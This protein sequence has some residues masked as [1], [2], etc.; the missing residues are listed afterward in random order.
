MPTYTTIP[1]S[2]LSEQLTDTFGGYNHNYKIG[3]GEFHDMKNLTSDYYPLMGNRA[4]RSLIQSGVFATIGGI[5]ADGDGDLYVIGRKATD[6][7][8]AVT[9]LYKIYKYGGYA[10]L[11]DVSAIAKNGDTVGSLVF[12]QTVKQQMCIFNNELVIFPKQVKV[13]LTKK[14]GNYEWSELGAAFAAFPLTADEETPTI[15]IR[16]CDGDGNLISGFAS[17]TAPESPTDGFIWIDTANDSIVW[18]KYASSQWISMSDVYVRICITYKKADAVDSPFE[19]GDAVEISTLVANDRFTSEIDGTHTIQKQWYEY[20]S[21][22]YQMFF[23][24]IGVIS[25]DREMNVSGDEFYMERKIPLMDFVVQSQNRLWGCRYQE[26]SASSDGIN[27]IYACKLGDA[28]N[29]NVYQGISTDSYTASC[30]TL[31]KF[32]GAANV[33]GYPIFFKENCYHKVYVSSTGAHQIQDKAINGVQDGCSGSVAMVGDICYYKSRAGIVAFD[34]SATYSTGDN[35][36]DIR[37]TEAVGG[38]ANDK[39]YISMK[40]SSGQWT[41]FAYDTSKSLWHKED[42]S[43]ALMFCSMSGDTFFVTEESNNACNINLISDYNK[44]ATQE[45]APEWEAVT[46]LQGYSY[47]GQKYISRFNLRMVLPKGSY[48]DIY[49]EYD[50]SGKWEHQGHIKGAGTTSFM[51]PVR[52][53]RCD[54]FRIKLAGAGDVRLY[55][56]S[57]LFEGGT[58]VR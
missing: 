25:T 55:S 17:A 47:T 16:A 9:K 45:T 43:H 3:D 12:P 10:T 42:S 53:R 29:W 24:I 38:S 30:G 44:T 35:L 19:A 13:S 56:M 41:I 2:T 8:T 50:S 57:K 6:T 32:T 4:A 21:G 39:Y 31:G 15:A 51:I 23:V 52:P 34:G 27:E 7:A 54:H 48:M 20:N 36:G 18:K 14:S 26:A 22:Y 28:A 46:G 11:E 58:D 33:N 37:Y 40:D 49:I 5:T 1:E